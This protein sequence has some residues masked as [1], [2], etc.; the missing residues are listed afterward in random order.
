M[1]SSSFKGTSE[2]MTS[3]GTESASADAK[4]NGTHTHTH[5]HTHHDQSDAAD[6][7]LREASMMHDAKQIHNDW[8]NCVPL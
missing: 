1:I 8:P 5:T 3:M 4:T 2:L 7:G 6:W